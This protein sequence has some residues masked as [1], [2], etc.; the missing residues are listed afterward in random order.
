MQ[1]AGR[2]AS[3]SVPVRTGRRGQG[4]NRPCS[5]S[6]RRVRARRRRSWSRPCSVHRARWCRRRPSPTWCAPRSEARRHGRAVSALRPERDRRPTA[7]RASRCAG[8]RWRAAARGTTPC[9]SPG[10]LSVRPAQARQATSVGA[11][12]GS[13]HWTERA[14]ALLAP[15]LHAAALDGADLATVLAWV[16]RRNAAPPLGILDATGPHAPATCWPGSPPPTPGSRAGSGQRRRG[17]WPPTEARPPWPRTV[18]PD[19][20]ARGLLRLRRP[21]CISVRTGRHQAVAA[22][23]VVGLLTDI[24]TAAYARSPPGTAAMTRHGAVPPPVDAGPGRGG[25]HRAHPRPA[26][27]GERRRRP[28]TC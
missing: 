22:P 28:G 14:E 2:P 16:D 24:R 9:S 23:L 27:D 19:F 13:D 25:Q 3:T 26:G 15:V 4:P 10:V 21:R 6:D 12:A 7:R 20:D 8:R 5:C 11:H 1:A 18:A 17:C